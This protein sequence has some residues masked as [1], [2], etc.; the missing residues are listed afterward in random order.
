MNE[1][2][3]NIRNELNKLIENK[4]KYSLLLEKSREFDEL[5]NLR[6]DYKYLT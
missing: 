3:E 5:M 6:N 4:T 2:L 1:K